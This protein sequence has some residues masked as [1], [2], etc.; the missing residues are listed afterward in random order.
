MGCSRTDRETFKLS[1]DPQFVPKLPDVVGVY[2]N[3]PQN[4]VVLCVDEK[5]QIQALDRTQPDLP[6]KR[7]RCGTGRRLRAPWHDHAVCRIER[8]RRQDQRP[9]LP[10]PPAHR[11]LK[12]LR[13][14][15]AE[16]AEADEL[17]LIVD[18]YGT[19]KHERVQ[20]WLAR[21]PR[22][23]LHFIPTSSSWL[24]LVERWFAELTGKAV[25]R[26]SFSSVPDLINLDH[27]LHR[28]ME[29]EPTPFVWTAKAEDILARIERCRRRL[30]A[31]QPGCTRRK[32]RKKAA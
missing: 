22:F 11:V 3:P 1:R 10:A 13:Q 8:G 15:D 28:A 30:E 9:L 6:L 25:R 32:P 17:H 12:F 20:R 16:Y 31:I 18:N 7:G 5:S 14:I 26:G 4:A 23:K 27:P 29:P 2:L 24:N 21:R 19:H